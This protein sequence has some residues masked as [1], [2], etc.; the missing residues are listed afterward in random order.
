M[1]LEFDVLWEYPSTWEYLYAITIIFLFYSK[2]FFVIFRGYRHII[3]LH[4]LFVILQKQFIFTTFINHNGTSYQIMAKF[5][6]RKL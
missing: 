1:Y 5:V 6:A 4:K 2:T 3:E